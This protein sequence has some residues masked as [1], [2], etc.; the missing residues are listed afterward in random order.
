MDDPTATYGLALPDNDQY[1]NLARRL[2]Q[3]ARERLCLVFFWVSA[4][5][6]VT[7][8]GSSPAAGGP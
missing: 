5:G 8:E 4:S 6:Q 3:L 7:V 2:P 1:R